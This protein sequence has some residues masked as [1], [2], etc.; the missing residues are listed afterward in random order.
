MEIGIHLPQFGPLANR[1]GVIGFAKMA[2]EHGFDSLWVSDH[3]IIPRK[4]E[5]RYPYSPDGSFPIPPDMPLL[6]PIA[7]MIFAAA[8]TER[9]KLGTTV[10]VIPMRN[11]IVTAKML[12]TLD[13]F[14]NGRLIL[15]VGAGWMEEEFRALGVP[16]ERRGARTDEYIRIFKALWTEESPSF[17][18]KFW[19]FDEL[20]FAPKPRPK[21]HPPIWVGG[22][23]TP[24]RRRAGRLGDAWHAVGVD[25]EQLGEQFKEV[26]RHAEEA[27][28]DPASIELTVRAR[29][30]LK[31][32]AQAAEQLEQ[33]R[34]VGVTHATVEIFT[35]DLDRAREL[36]DVLSSE[37][38]PKIGV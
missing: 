37:V 25:A 28:R 9:A 3:V 26:R 1:E 35:A 38:R 5:A 14:S 17:D 2:E 36:M 4:I 18:G 10:L 32:P 21:P 15:G 29:V 16:F 6:E 7:T 13:V 23:S 19:Q 20:G 33:Y 34:E 31:Q 12:A 24:A 22:H 27:G 11:P 30:N 8:V